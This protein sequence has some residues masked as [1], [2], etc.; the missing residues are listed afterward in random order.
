M[1]P[2]KIVKNLEEIEE[3]NRRVEAEKG[4]E[5]S[6][7]RR[8]L[9]ALGTYAVCYGYMFFLGIEKAHLH[10][11]IPPGAYLLST[12]SLRAFRLLWIKYLYKVPD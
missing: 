11:L 4:W 2:H 6:I 3:R 9:I 5:T 12:L 1:K 7:T 8:V 10:A